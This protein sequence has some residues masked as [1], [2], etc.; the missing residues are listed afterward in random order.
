VHLFLKEERSQGAG[1]KGYV[2]RWKCAFNPTKSPNINSQTVSEN[3]RKQKNKK[4]EPN[5][6][7]DDE[8]ASSSNQAQ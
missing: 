1:A 8:N 3:R 5:W 6:N 7:E 2:T 4:K